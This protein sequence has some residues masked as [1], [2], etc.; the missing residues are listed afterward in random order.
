MDIDT[1]CVYLKLSF[2]NNYI[3][4]PHISQLNCFM[5][6][7][8]NPGT[9][10]SQLMSMSRAFKTIFGCHYLLPV[11]VAVGFKPSNLRIMY[12]LLCNRASGQFK[13]ILLSVYSKVISFVSFS[14]DV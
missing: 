6:V 10:M 9:G 7:D 2:S 1:S 12:R 11:Q 14:L 5:M 8:L 13:L 3:T 4:S